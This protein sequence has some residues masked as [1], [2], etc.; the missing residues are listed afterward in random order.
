MKAWQSSLAAFATMS[1]VAL[2]LVGGANVVDTTTASASSC[3]TAPLTHVGNIAGIQAPQPSMG[4]FKSSC[5]A[6]ASNGVK[7]TPPYFIYQYGPLP[8]NGGPVM[9]T[10]STPVTITP[11][12][13]APS[14][15]GFASTYQSI[16]DQFIKDSAAVGGSSTDYLSVLS[17]YY[18]GTSNTPILNYFTAGTPIIDT[19]TYPTSGGCTADT[20]AVYSD[21]SCYSACLTDLQI[22]TEITSVLSAHSLPSD[23]NHLYLM[24]LPKGVE[25]CFNTLNNTGGGSCTLSSQGGAFC[26]YHSAF[27]SVLSPTVYADLPYAIA[28]TPSLQ[29]CS[30]DG[31][32]L[33]GGGQVGN[34][35]PNG[36]LDADTVI[37]VTSHEI[38]ESVT[39]PLPAPGYFGWIDGSYHEVGDDCAYIYG[40]SLAFG[41]TPGAEYN[42]TINGDHYFIQEEFSD[43]QYNNNTNYSCALMSD[44]TVLFD[45][46]GG[47]GV[48]VPQNEVLNAVATI[49]PN[50]FTRQNYTFTG[51]NSSSNGSGTTYPNGSNVKFTASA[52][53]YA[54]W[55]LTPSYTVTFNPNGGT[56]LMGSDTS[57]VSGVLPA[58]AFS[59]TGY[60]FEG[61]N[62]NP[63][64][65]GTSYA[66]LAS[67]GFGAN[68]TLY[69][70]WATDVPSAPVIIKVVAGNNS[71]TISW[72]TPSAPFGM[73]LAGYRIHAGYQPG[74]T[75]VS[76]YRGTGVIIGTTF[77]ATHLVNGTKY[78]FEVNALDSAG[79]SGDST[80]S[81]VTIPRGATTTTLSLSK[82]VVTF[83]HERSTVFKVRVVSHNSSDVPR[84]TVDVTLGTKVLCK[85]R[86]SS[87]GAGSCVMSSHLVSKG[88][89]SIV[90]EFVANSY[91]TG[92]KSKSEPFRIT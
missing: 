7:A 50:S 92:S 20:G 33:S 83:T 44:Q 36:N 9:D 6:G 40:D 74:D 26:G 84:G 41:G 91:D 73:T 17:Q 1:M 90:A 2:G 55:A 4:V 88:R 13:W 11:I 49:E 58:N 62:T 89:H 56:G 78:Y 52:T 45:P 76:L 16:T 60:T 87:T 72:T 35:S 67:Y 19:D 31:G 10:T 5:T 71:A 3:V 30:S 29:T 77:H 47:S 18:N 8:Y 42:Q 59:R 22:Q 39:D 82:T 81:G 25:S 79:A 65:T 68:A 85:I 14:P 61:W 23:L 66:N 43:Y 57:N 54:Q 38:S 24:Y 69:A 48:M 51:W 15:F 37:S 28:D 32:S 53:F 27:G 86:L 34:Q 63:S 80:F 21:S 12:Y 70:Q 64:G 46:N 75:S